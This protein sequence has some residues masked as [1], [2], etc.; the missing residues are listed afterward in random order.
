MYM[1]WF[2]FGLCINPTV[3]DRQRRLLE[4]EE[5]YL[6]DVGYAPPTFE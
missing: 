4:E 5:V 1:G 2:C 6:L 3:T